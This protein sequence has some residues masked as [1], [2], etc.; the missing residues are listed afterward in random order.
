MKSV[1]TPSPI[2]EC[3]NEIS[4]LLVTQD[5]RSLAVVTWIVPGPAARGWL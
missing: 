4:I 5:T 1:D 3:G 2:W